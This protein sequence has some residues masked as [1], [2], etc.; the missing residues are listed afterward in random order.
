M[1]FNHNLVRGETAWRV[2]YFF[3]VLLPAERKYAFWGADGPG[4]RPIFDQFW[5]VPLDT[6]RHHPET[7]FP[8]GLFKS[9]HTESYSFIGPR[10][11]TWH[12]NVKDPLL[13]AFL[14]YVRLCQDHLSWEEYPPPPPPRD[15]RRRV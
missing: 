8:W 10:G 9:V 7:E 1:A 12:R 4:T 2:R 15:I 3:T 6:W 13:R 11:R 5:Y 14:K